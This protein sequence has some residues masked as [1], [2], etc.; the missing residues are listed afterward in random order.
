[1]ACIGLLFSPRSGAASIE[2]QVAYAH[3]LVAYAD[4]AWEAALGHFDTAV[5]ADPEDAL[6]RYYRGLTHARRGNY[7]GAA[8]DI[9][10]ALQTEPLLPG[11]ALDLGVVLFHQGR[12]VDARRALELA[13]DRPNERGAATFFLGL[14][15]YRL[16]EHTDALRWFEA[17]AEDP[18]LRQVALYYSGLA[19]LRDG[20]PERARR[21]L[22]EAAAV[23]PESEIGQRA[24]SIDVG[25]PEP[26]LVTRA[27]PRALRSWLLYAR[28]QL[29]FDSNVN[30]G[31][32]SGP[33]ATGAESD[34]RP[35]LRAGGRYRLYTGVGGTVLASA[36]LS[37]SIHFDQRDF[38]LT[39]LRLRVDWAGRPEPLRFGVAL[40]YEYFALEYTGFS[41]ALV[42]QP[43]TAYQWTEQ[44]T[45]Q[46]YYRFR[47]R[48]YLSAPFDPFRDGF[49]NALGLR[50][51][52]AIQPE[53][54]LHAG[55][56]IDMESPEDTG[57]R[58]GWL[59]T[60]AE[61]FEATGHQVDAGLAMPLDIPWLGPSTLRG[62]YRLRLDDY[63][64]ANT[65]S[66]TANASL[67]G[68]KRRDLDNT[69]ALELAPRLDPGA[70]G[71]AHLIDRLELTVGL[72][73]SVRTS[74]L[75]PFEA[76]RVIGS[77][78]LRAHF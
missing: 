18:S 46:V 48:D 52:W 63:A 57:S 5:T 26:E 21:R 75:D 3:G 56:Q 67:A 66:W 38:D 58:D 61:D 27:R 44:T 20:D 42:F 13:L 7:A 51:Y 65:R 16:G 40:A 17:A 70:I 24:A 78:G 37:Q 4:A 9:R 62:G 22:A 50:Q 43:W 2:S 76:T 33:D 68:K 15:A 45:S 19:S 34:V 6:A 8:E 39:G 49:N 69:I 32:S 74:N 28:T 36:D 30:A 55:Y 14:S 72:I 41:Q 60:G 35:V 47:F 73:G 12:F 31:P 54:I 10:S 77:L 1:M 71:L 11:A 23:A 53:L 25:S 64:N 29:E 59:A